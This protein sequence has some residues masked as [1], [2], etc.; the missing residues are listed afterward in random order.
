MSAER[1]AL[2]VGDERDVV[3]GP[4]AHG[5]HFI[6][7][8]DDR[9]LFV[10]HTLP[11]ERVRVRVTEVTSRIVRADAI[12]ILDPS[13]DR[14][15]APCPWSGPG[16]CGGC[17]FQHVSLVA[18]RRLKTQVLRESL[19]RFGGIAAD[20]AVLAVE[21]TELPGSPDG[22]RWRTRMTWASALDGSRGLRRHRS[23]DVIAVDDCLIAEA[24]VSRPDAPPRGKIARTVRVRTWRIGDGD[25]WQV[26]PALP[27][28]LVESVLEFGLPRPGQVWWDLYAGAG[29]F[30]AFLG[31][32][33]GPGGSVEAV[34]TSFIAL[35]TARRALHDLP[36][37][38]LHGADVGAW[39]SVTHGQPP[40]GVVLDPPRAGAGARIVDA[41]ARWGRPT[42][43]YVAC[44]PVAL[45]RD[46]S[47][48]AGH[49][50]RL[51]ALRAFDAFPMTHHL[52]T[53]ALLLPASA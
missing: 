1:G 43:V 34:E 47:L 6:A 8:S 22:L 11:G 12:E 29:L 10:R 44:D 19:Q 20:D 50:Y 5:G 28:A 24:V 31:E 53:V 2:T 16:L 35:R 23:H 30:S 52:E 42:V 9:T 39:L 25:F 36:N 15:P 49:G 48:F 40:D 7:H 46:I 27:E 4:V 3:V 45:A 51:E 13:P 18:Q 32:A 14:V 26:H 21:V 37:V 17:D 38:H 41:I 33:V